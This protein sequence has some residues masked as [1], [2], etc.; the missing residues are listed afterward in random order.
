LVGVI[1]ATQFDRRYY[2]LHG[3]VQCVT[4]LFDLDF[5]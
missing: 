5:R 3:T 4:L 2:M 1:L